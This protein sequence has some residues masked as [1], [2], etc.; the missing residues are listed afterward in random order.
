MRFIRSASSRGCIMITRLLV[1]AAA[2]EIRT[3]RTRPGVPPA[4]GAPWRIENRALRL[5]CV[6]KRL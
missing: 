1:D 3:S 5:L 2:L 6:V 4:R